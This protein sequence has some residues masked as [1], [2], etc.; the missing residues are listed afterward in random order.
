[1]LKLW[2]VLYDYV[3][4]AL[5]KLPHT[6][7]DAAIHYFEYIVLALLNNHK[8]KESSGICVLF[9]DFVSIQNMH[10]RTEGC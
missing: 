9:D 2:R 8:K 5:Y 4:G 10:S 6:K 1:V 7:Y 3:N